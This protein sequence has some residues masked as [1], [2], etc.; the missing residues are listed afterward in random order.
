MAEKLMVVCDVCSKPA[1]ETV[2]LRTSSGNRVK[3]LC[4]VHLQELLAGSRAPKRG[5]RPGAAIAV[6]TTAG[7]RTTATRK[8]S[9]RKKVAAGR[10][11]A[12]RKKT[13]ARPGYSKNGKRLGRPPASK[14]RKSS[15]RKTG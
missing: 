9:S 7:A 3:D 4:A 13:V 15:S 14:A 1:V 6:T 10:K 12:A 5:R 8:R 11:D 2:T